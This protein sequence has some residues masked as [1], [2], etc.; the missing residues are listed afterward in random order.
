MPHNLR[1]LQSRAKQH[2]VEHTQIAVPHPGYRFGHKHHVFIAK[3]K[4]GEI[5]ALN[6]LKPETKIAVTP[7]LEMWPPNPATPTKPAK[8]LTDHTVGLLTLATEWTG[9]PCYVDT[10]YLQAGGVPS[11]AGA[12]TVFAIART[13]GV[14]AVPVTSPYFSQLSRSH[15]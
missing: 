15:Q 13:L 8:P 4:R 14:N 3:L 1:K 2:S 11:P 7:L 6:H 5:W 10:Q 9:L 12:Q